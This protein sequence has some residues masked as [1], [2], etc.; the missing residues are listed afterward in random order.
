MSLLPQ[1]PTGREL[2]I[3]QILWSRG[4]S[5]VREVL[6]VMNKG[7]EEPL[8]TPRFFGSSKS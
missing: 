3:M 4:P 7:R 8:P 5:T 2:E 1:K 6:D